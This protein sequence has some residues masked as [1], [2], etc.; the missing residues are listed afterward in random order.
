MKYEILK[1][2]KITFL[3]QTLFRI[4]S[5]VKIEKYGVNPGNLG[6]YILSENNLSQYGNAWVSDNAWVYGNAKVYGNA[7]V[8]GYANVYGDAIVKK[9]GECIS[10]NNQK[11]NITLTP[12]LIVIGCKSWKTLKEFEKTYKKIGLANGYT[13]D[14]CEMTAELVRAVM[15]RI[16]KNESETIQVKHNGQIY[17]IDFE[18]AKELGLL[19]WIR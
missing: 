7:E 16:G 1:D 15:K 13:E 14:E 2:D 17:K 19:K 3:G 8:S 12:N 6:G 10:I 5:K 4:K 18:K 11:N 9:Y